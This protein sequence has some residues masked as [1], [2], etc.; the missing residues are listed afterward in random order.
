MSLLAMVAP[1]QDREPAPNERWG[2][3]EVGFSAKVDGLSQRSG[4]KVPASEPQ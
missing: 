4:L 1:G 2:V 3:L